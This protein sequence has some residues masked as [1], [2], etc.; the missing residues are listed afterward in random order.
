MKRDGKEKEKAGTRKMKERERLIERK[1]N[2]KKEDEQNEKR[3]DTQL[4]GQNRNRE[5]EKEKR[6]DC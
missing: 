6:K 1:K 2:V 5:I 4:K 3:I